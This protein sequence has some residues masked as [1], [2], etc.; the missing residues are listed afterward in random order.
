VAI[1]PALSLAPVVATR[2]VAPQLKVDWHHLPLSPRLDP[3]RC[4]GE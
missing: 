4:G 2:G 1:V 3:S